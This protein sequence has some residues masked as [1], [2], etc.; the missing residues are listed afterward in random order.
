[1]VKD[2]CGGLREN[3][4]I[5]DQIRHCGGAI[6]ACKMDWYYSRWEC[7]LVRSLTR[8]KCFALLQEVLKEPL[9][10]NDGDLSAKALYSGV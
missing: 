8:Q 9:L 2:N 4:L 1:M 3:S 7:W 5:G 6:M 10:A